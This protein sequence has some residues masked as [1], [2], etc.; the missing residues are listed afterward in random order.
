MI[1]DLNVQLS[2]THSNVEQ[3]DGYLIGPDGQRIELF[4]ANGGSDDHFDRTIFN[5]ET[6][7][8]ITRARPPFRGEFQPSAVIKRQPSLSAYKGTSLKGV[9]QLMIRSSRSDRS[10]ILHNCR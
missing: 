2:I 5:D 6:G 8:S 1:G 10:G 4:S 3:L 7:I 9:W